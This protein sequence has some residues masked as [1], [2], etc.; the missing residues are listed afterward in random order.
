MTPPMPTN[1]T[2]SAVARARAVELLTDWLN[3]WRDDTL[4]GIRGELHSPGS[5]IIDLE[6]RIMIALDAFARGREAAVWE[7]AAKSLDNLAARY[8]KEHAPMAGEDDC[9]V[10]AEV[11]REVAGEMRLRTRAAEARRTG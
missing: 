1:E 6:H 4:R 9:M 2:P 8:E 11:L 5:E 7:E 10:K 3:Q